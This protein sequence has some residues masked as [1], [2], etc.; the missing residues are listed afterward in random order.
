MFA[1][2]CG[3]S[4]V[5]EEAQELA[6]LNEVSARTLDPEFNAS[7]PA[8]LLACMREHVHVHVVLRAVFQGFSRPW[9][10]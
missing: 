5:R 1:N 2:T 10:P 3:S 9:I 4:Y 8:L 6:G 7:R